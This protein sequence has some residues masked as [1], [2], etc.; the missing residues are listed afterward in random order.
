MLKH[1]AA[2]DGRITCFNMFAGLD[3]EFIRRRCCGGD[4]QR[5]GMNSQAE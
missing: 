4:N 3:A 2:D 1:V 5:L